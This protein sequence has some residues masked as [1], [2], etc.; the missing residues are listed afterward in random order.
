MIT[1][2]T[3]R[4][5]LLL[6]ASLYSIAFG[7][8]FGFLNSYF[9]DDWYTYFDQTASDI[10]NNVIISGFNPIRLML[11]GF[12]NEN[13][14]PGF[15]ILIFIFYPL[16]AYAL[17]NVLASKSYLSSFEAR[18]I[19]LLFLLAPVNSARAAVMI[20][21]YTSCM[22]AFFVAWWLYNSKSNAFLRI[23]SLAL[24]V[25]SFDTASFIPFLLVPIV[26]TYLDS[27]VARQ[28]FFEWIKSNFLLLVIGP[29][30]WFTE[31]LL[32]P[33]L[34]PIRDAY[35]QPK[36]SGLIRAV[37]Y[38]VPVLA[39]ALWGFVIRKWRYS[40]QRGQVQVVLGLLTCW[41]A[42]FPYVALGH[43]ANLNSVIVG[44]VPN[45]SD[46]DSRHQLL[47]PVGIALTLIG[48][49]NY[50]DS[51]RSQKLV[52]AMALVFSSLNFSF[53]QEYYLDALKQQ[54]IIKSLADNNDLSGFDR[55]LIEDTALRFNARGRSIRT[56][57]WDRIISA[58]SAGSKKET[59]ITRFIDC[60]EFN[61]D[62]K[63]TISASS[64]R[65]RALITRD[66]G[67]TL[68]VEKISIC[69]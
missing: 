44:F 34:D 58:N 21:M 19:T 7:Y 53:T 51:S 39:I 41:L 59:E 48:L 55:L 22:C 46:W 13:F 5:F 11:E 33:N 16:A 15:R 23:L 26:F 12:L 27:R 28:S 25:Y 36:I 66:V 38:F 4:G 54:Q 29:S 40:N 43:F 69:D 1:K 10:R 18:S 31:P 49:I 42:I 2:L 37:V 52:V 67:I 45:L 50:L 62:A 35:Y 17:H 63:L 47:L 24:F 9:W 30:F 61:P 3:S 32:N 68:A 14:F 6:C 57:E 8:S 56:Y 65:L 60:D 64:G 20:F